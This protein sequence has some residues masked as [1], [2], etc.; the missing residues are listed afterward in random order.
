MAST[1]QGDDDNDD[2]ISE[3]EAVIGFPSALA[4]LAG[5]TVVIAVLSEYVVGTIEVL[6]VHCTSSFWLFLN[7]GG[8]IES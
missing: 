8:C 4:W 3:D 7:S 6:F 2:V 1:Q 5:M